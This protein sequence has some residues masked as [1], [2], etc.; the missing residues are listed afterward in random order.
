MLSP[1]NTYTINQSLPWHL[2]ALGLQHCPGSSPRRFGAVGSPAV[3]VPSRSARPHRPRG[4]VG[5]VL[6]RFR[7]KALKSTHPGLAEPRGGVQAVFMFSALAGG[8]SH[9]G[10]KCLG[11]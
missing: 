10:D 6:E 5:H 7:P 9:K 8:S 2:G 4:E 1:I 3:P 11:R